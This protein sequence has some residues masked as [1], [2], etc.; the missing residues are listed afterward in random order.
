M[1]KKHFAATALALATALSTGSAETLAAE[2]VALREG[3]VDIYFAP[4]DNISLYLVGFINKAQRRVW[5][6]GYTLTMPAIIH[7]I[8]QAKARGLDVRVVLD[9]AQASEKS[10]GA[11]FLR[12]AGVPVWI[13]SRH[14]TMN[15][16]FLVCDDDRVG[17]GSANFTKASM[18]WRK[19]E[20]TVRH[21]ENFNLFVGVPMLA[22]Q[23]ADEFERLTAESSR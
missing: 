22:K 2:R 1:A 17:F 6:A 12:K 21:S 10:S 18:A 9:H 14:L 7:A 20:Q 16:K 3:A 8:A 23:Y 13:N 11:S 19:G 15:Q 4:Q 5:L